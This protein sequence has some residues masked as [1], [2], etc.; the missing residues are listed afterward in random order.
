MSSEVWMWIGFNV[1]VLILLFLDLRVFHRKTHVIGIREALLWS[2]FW[3]GLSLLF[4]LGI[5]FWRGSET[6]LHFLTAYL[7]EKSLSVD[8]LFVFLLIFTYFAVPALYQHKVLFWGILGAI[9]MRLAFILAGVAIVERFH[10]ALYILGAFL[11]VAAIRLALRKDE[12]IDPGRN[13][14][15]RLFRRFV[16]VTEDYEG[17][18]FFVR[19]AGLWMA[20]P[21]LI[22]VLVVETTDIVF[23]VDSV[24]AVL[25][26]TL[27]RFIAYSS[28]VCAIL[29][30]RALYFALAGVIGMFRYLS[31]GLA[32]VLFFIGV[33]MLVVDVYE[34]P[35]GIALGVV[36]GV[37]IIS[38]AMSL[39]NPCDEESE[40][41]ACRLQAE[42]SDARPAGSGGEKD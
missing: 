31:Y 18:R 29:G 16:R 19:R 37:L 40:E 38:I 5:Y 21:L 22:V 1:V 39:L 20:T 30:L 25:G 35:V 14:V 32:A 41:A 13:P 2:A 33:K 15:L 9:V 26:I 28:N 7:I 23:A 6:A 3:I 36:G 34:M 27:D 4:N 17:D 11:V 42:K 12:K 24:P 8:N 10:W